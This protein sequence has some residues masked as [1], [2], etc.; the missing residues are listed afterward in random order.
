MG[1][2]FRAEED[3]ET[4]IGAT[5]VCG[6]DWKKPET[7][8]VEMSSEYS[9]FKAVCNTEYDDRDGFR[10]DMRVTEDGY[11]VV[12]GSVDLDG[13]SGD[14]KASLTA[15]DETMSLKGEYHRAKK[16]VTVISLDSFTVDE[17][18]YNLSGTS[19]TVKENDKMPVIKDY[20]DV[21]SMSESDVDRMAEDIEDFSESFMEKLTDSLGF[22]AYFLF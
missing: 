5:A 21:L 20:T 15:D 2:A 10:S 4:A 3:G 6:P 19:V 18:T 1:V 16:D 22:L 8:K 17:E 12:S 13:S 11:T 14:F 9:E 7:I